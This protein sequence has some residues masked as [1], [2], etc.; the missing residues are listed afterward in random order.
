MKDVCKCEL[1]NFISECLTQRRS[2]AD[3]S[4]AKFSE[5][6]MIDL[7][8]YADPERGESFCCT[9]KFIAFLVYCCDDP[10]RILKECRAILERTRVYSV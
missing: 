8:A 6:P 1:L 2:E 5:K 7:C 3:L 10:V 9:L 4:Q